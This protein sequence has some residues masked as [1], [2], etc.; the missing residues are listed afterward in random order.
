MRE[1]FTS[2]SDSVARTEEIACDFAKILKPGDVVAL[3][4]D[5]GAG[6]TAFVRGLTSALGGNG[7]TVSSPTFSLVNEYDADIKIFHFDVYR[8]ENAGIDELDWL[9]DYLFNDG[10]C[11]IEWAEYVLSVLP[12]P[13]YRVDIEKISE[14][15]RIF[16]CRE[17]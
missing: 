2:R 14:A 15:E 13:Y 12:K 17:C 3:C 4:G 10:V 6:K 16:T 5:L 1:I 11:L 7:K 9:D 8:L